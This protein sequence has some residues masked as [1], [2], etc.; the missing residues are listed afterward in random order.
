MYNSK[1]CCGELTDPYDAYEWS[2][3]AVPAQKLAGVTKSAY[4]KGKENDM[5]KILSM[6]ESKKSFTLS[7]SDCSKLS[8]YIGSLQQ[9][10]KDGVFYRDSL[11]G[12]VVRLS[13]VVQPDISRE[14]M[15]SIAK[16]MT[17]AQLKEFKTAFEKKK[18]ESIVPVPQL[19]NEKNKSETVLNGQFKI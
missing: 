8:A 7:D 18:N 17:V 15:E 3:V 5:N 12:E 1:L 2:F 6:I 19:Y 16:T 4:T 14:T 13:A 9:S 10:A 11:T